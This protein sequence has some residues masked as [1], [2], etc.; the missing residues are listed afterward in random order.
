MDAR[1]ALRKRRAED[2]G[3]AQPDPGPMVGDSMPKLRREAKALGANAV[4]LTELYSSTS[5]QRAGAFGLSAGVAMD[6]RLGWDLSLRADQVKAEK[7]MSDDKPHSLI[8]SPM[9]LSLSLDFDT[10]TQTNWQNCGSKANV[11]WSLHAAWQD[12]K[13]SKMDLFSLSIPR[14]RPRSRVRGAVLWKLRSIDGMRCVRSDQCQF[15]MTLIDSEGNV[16]PACKASGQM[17]NGE[18]IEE[19]VNRHF[20]WTRSHPVVERQ[21]VI[22]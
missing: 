4:A 19:A 13:S 20:W 9:C 10:P 21:S 16:G 18:H 5:R 11:I 8:L 3:G 12:C 7:R 22:F 14:Q 17:T 15:G 2:A 6:L 1:E